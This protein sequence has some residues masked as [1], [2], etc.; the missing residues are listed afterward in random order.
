MN[1]LLTST[2]KIW[3][4]IT[5]RLI[6]LNYSISTMESCTS[7]LVA[8]MITNEPGAS[9]I[10]KGAFVTYSNEAK[11]K[12]GIS[13]YIIDHYGV[14]SEATAEE[15]AI[16]C[17]D[18]YKATIGIGVTG[19]LDR[20]DPNN[21]TEDK[22]IFYAIFYQDKTSHG[23]LM[24]SVNIP[25]NITDRFE[26]KLYVVNNIGVRLYDALYS[27]ELKL[28]N[29]SIPV[30]IDRPIEINYLD[31]AELNARYERIKPLVTINGLTYT[32]RPFKPHELCDQ[33]Y[34]WEAEKDKRKVIDKERLEVIENFITLHEY[35][36]YGLFKPSINEVLSQLPEK[37]IKE[38]Q[39]FEIIESPRTR[40]DVFRYTEVVN[41]G[42]HAAVVRTYK[43]KS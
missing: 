35:G 9:A 21:P 11:I 12:Q 5:K 41:A 26:R 18:Q 4:D 22:K 42:Y 7:G 6:E 37:S 16:N 8:T 30:K 13:D 17:A 28:Y 34:I 2:K 43:V 14:Y 20:I 15:M 36:Y 40:S 23:T 24:Y 31:E 10:M 25:D 27:T 39:Y 29:N 19:V 38:A 32:L 3:S 1:D 33:S